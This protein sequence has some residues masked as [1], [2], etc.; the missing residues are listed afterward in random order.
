MYRQI[1]AEVL[2]AEFVRPG[3]LDEAEAIA[4]GRQLLYDNVRTIF[5]V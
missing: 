1:L 5:R 3:L 2:A 4:L